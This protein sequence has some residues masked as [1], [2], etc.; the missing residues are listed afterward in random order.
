MLR[1]LLNLSVSRN[2]IVCVDQ[3]SLLCY[4][5]FAVMCVP[6]ELPVLLSDGLRFHKLHSAKLP[7]VIFVNYFYHVMLLNTPFIALS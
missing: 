1:N 5:G 3:G 6:Y 2:Q 7:V 4:W